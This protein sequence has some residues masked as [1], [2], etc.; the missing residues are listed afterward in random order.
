MISTS[1]NIKIQKPFLKWVGGKTQI[2]HHI[3]Q[4]FPKEMNHYHEI[5]LGGGSVLLALLSYAKAEAITIHGTVHAYDLNEPLIHL[6]KN[7]QSFPIELFQEVEQI[8]KEYKEC[9]S[10]SDSTKAKRRPSC[11]EEAKSSQESYYYWVR[12]TYNN[13]SNEEKNTTFGSALFL[14]LNKTCFRGL[15]RIGPSGFNVP[16]GH[17]KNP[18]VIDFQQVFIVHELIQPVVFKV[19]DFSTSIQQAKE[20]DFV[21]L[22][23]PYAPE[24]ETS[25]VGY[26]SS[27]FSMKEHQ[28]M[29]ELIHSALDQLCV[30]MM[31][32][33]S[34]VPLTREAFKDASY[35]IQSVRCKRAIHSKK[36][37]SKTNE[38]IVTNYQDL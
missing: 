17:Y 38:I 33:N 15:F 18:K 20:D 1:Q 3:M 34:D 36:P 30:K 37:E 24:K 28:T 19:A 31:M 7:I 2:I 16:F 5:F 25:F 27:G 13:L 8:V 35:T 9:A 6:Y 29:F 23:P 11:L 14:F 26:T 10:T 4:Q 32:S 22:D 12:K 21:Y